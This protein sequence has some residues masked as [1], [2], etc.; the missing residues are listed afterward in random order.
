MQT[1]STNY[2]LELVEA[3]DE[4][5]LYRS[6]RVRRP[7]GYH[8]KKPGQYT[9]LQV[10]GGEAGPSF[11]AIAS[12]PENPEY[13]EFL[14]KPEGD[15]ALELV[16]CVPGDLV[17]ARAPLGEGFSTQDMDSREV[18]MFASGTGIAPIVPLCRWL[19]DT[20]GLAP[21]RLWVFYGE[22]GPRDFALGE[23]LDALAARGAHIFRACSD[24]PAQTGGHRFVQEVF[25]ASG[26]SPL[27]SAIVICGSGRMEQAVTTYLA[28]AGFPIEELRRNY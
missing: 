25:A 12:D 19:A 2:S 8:Y 14:I 16:A 10:V 11:F 15:T 27:E 6:L 5:T 23:P 24:D 22:N 4:G 13:L 7:P 20:K 21:E 28:D 9:T 26:P 17:E 1:G 3:K 18:V